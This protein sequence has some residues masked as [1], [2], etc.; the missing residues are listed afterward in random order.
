MPGPLGLT[1]AATAHAAL[2]ILH[3]KRPAD[4]PMVPN[5]QTRCFLNPTLADRI[6]F[7]APAGRSC[8]AY[9]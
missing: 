1:T 8:A 2:A 4:I 9:R 3:G 7:H 6:G 5:Q